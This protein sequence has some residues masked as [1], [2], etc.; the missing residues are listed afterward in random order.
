MTEKT[1]SKTIVKDDPTL[2]DLQERYNMD[3]DVWA[4]SKR[5]FPFNVP[6]KFIIALAL[7]TPIALSVAWFDT[8]N[9]YLWKVYL[10]SLFFSAIAYFVTDRAIEQFKESLEKNG[11]FGKDLNKAG[12]RDKKPP[13]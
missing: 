3:A 2:A 6:L 4:R 11:L 8:S 13:V 9:L 12:E 10:Y 1:R 5:G 7:G